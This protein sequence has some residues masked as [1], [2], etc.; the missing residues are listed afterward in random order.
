MSRKESSLLSAPLHAY[1]AVRCWILV[2]RGHDSPS[3]WVAHCLEFDVVARSDGQGI[4]A[5]V[6]APRDALRVVFEADLESGADPLARGPAADDAWAR[7]YTLM[8]KSRALAEVPVERRGG[9]DWV[10]G[11]IL[12]R[13]P[14]G[15][16]E[17]PDPPRQLRS[18][19]TETTDPA[20]ERVVLALDELDVG[21]LWDL[22]TGRL[23]D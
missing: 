3:T 8:R 14:T 15:Q 23:P 22:H 9:V 7:L 11:Q 6:L 10:A 20:V 17:S 16:T 2:E 13:V 4:E 18:I 21:V 12:V 5:A 1:A 19:R